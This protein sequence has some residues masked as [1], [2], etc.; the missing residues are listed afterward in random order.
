MTLQERL[1]EQRN[2]NYPRPYLTWEDID[3]LLAEQTA[4]RASLRDVLSWSMAETPAAI[5][6]RAR[7][8]RAQGRAVI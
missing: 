4:L 2:H 8:L 1:G 5:N 7:E 6:E 3:G